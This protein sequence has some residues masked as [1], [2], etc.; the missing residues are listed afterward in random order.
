MN[1][2][3]Y[4]WK[5]VIA[6]DFVKR[7]TPTSR[8]SHYTGTWEELE[9]LV[10][11]HWETAKQGYRK[12]VILVEVPAGRFY[13]SVVEL[14]E[15]DELVGSF[16]PRRKG[17]DPRKVLTVRS[18]NKTPAAKVELVLYT[19]NVL[20]EDEDNMLPPEDG[21]WEIVSINASPVAGEMPIH[22]MVLMHNHF[23]SS[24]G[25][26][27]NLPDAAFVAM[28]RESFEFWKDKASCG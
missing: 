25:T 12:G 11:R 20:V 16:T 24:G 28:L 1:S 17:E 13:S 27:T 8:F 18:G 3:F 26:L 5:H 10:V 2:I 6:N 15:G 9:L 23:G 19:S 4:P 7:Q 21:N 22:P 14:S